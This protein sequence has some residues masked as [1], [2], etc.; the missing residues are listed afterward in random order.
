M[1]KIYWSEDHFIG[2]EKEEEIAKPWRGI[3]T[4]TLPRELKNQLTPHWQNWIIASPDYARYRCCGEQLKIFVRRK[5]NLVAV[6]SISDVEFGQEHYVLRRRPRQKKKNVCGGAI[7]PLPYALYE[8]DYIPEPPYVHRDSIEIRVPC[9]HDIFRAGKSKKL[10]GSGPY[11]LAV[12]GIVNQSNSFQLSWEPSK[13]QGTS[14]KNASRKVEK[15]AGVA[16]KDQIEGLT[17]GRYYLSAVT[18]QGS[19]HSI[20]F[21]I[22][23]EQL[24]IAELVYR[25]DNQTF[26]LLS[27]EE[28]LD[29]LHESE[30][31]DAVIKQLEQAYA[32]GNQN[33][34]DKAK[35]QVD[36]T[37]NHL[38]DAGGETGALT[39]VIGFRGKKF[40]YVTS[41]KM[42]NHTRSYK[43]DKDIDQKRIINSQ[44]KL[45]YENLKETFA[46][47]EA[48][49]DYTWFKVDPHPTSLN[50]W[51]DSVNRKLADILSPDKKLDPERRYDTTKAAQVLRYSYG[52]STKSNF[53]LKDKTF[54]IKASS[55]ASFAVAEGKI[56]VTGYLPKAKGHG[57]KFSYRV[58]H[59]IHAGMV[60]KFDFGL[61]RLKGELALAGFAGASCQASAGMT[62]ELDQG[63]VKARGSTKV[64]SQKGQGRG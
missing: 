27:E 19:S 24:V 26:Y 23:P 45:N 37:L 38:I 30:K 50:D 41:D 15:K 43:I 25:P 6:S 48:G 11:T 8:E 47:K 3:E 22:K 17:P 46:K 59:G 20:C 5:S 4:E 16:W 44:G 29:F 61:V 18:T 57:L 42:R 54:G 56:G 36:T 52:A 58:E 9:N 7:K 64:S 39:E 33:Q 32:G 14:R 63:K 35:G 1:T 49:L 40:T 55:E 2:V 34:I 62:F 51:A 21:T 53:S 12:S 60:K 13:E 10:I 28:Y 31:Y